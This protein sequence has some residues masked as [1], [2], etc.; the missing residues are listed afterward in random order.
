MVKEPT[1]TAIEEHR[2]RT[3][4]TEDLRRSAAGPA[5]G[6]DAAIQVVL[7]LLVLLSPL[8]MGAVAP[9]ARGAVFCAAMLIFALW[10]AQGFVRGRLC[11]AR[12][13]LWPLILAFFGL[14][15]FQL[16]PLPV[17]VLARLSPATFETRIHSTGSPAASLALSLFPYGTRSEICRLVALA[18]IFFVVAN[19][20]RAPRQVKILIL[21]LAA[22][23]VFEALY[24][25]AEQFSGSRHIFWQ[26]R[27]SH[28]EAVTGT[29]PN[30]NHF[31]GLQAMALTA[32]LGLIVALIPRN[33]RSR[34]AGKARLVAGISSP[35]TGQLMFLFGA[36]LLMAVAIVFSLSRAGILCAL[37]SLILFATC[38]GLAGGF[39]KYT[40]LLFFLVA[41]VVV[42]AA[43]VGTEI[44]LQRFEEAA[45]GRSASWADRL[46]LSRSGLRLL[47]EFPL[48]GTGLGTFRFAFE[49]FQSG[50]FGDHVADFLHNDWLQVSCETGVVG[51]LIVFAAALVFLLGA[52]RA[53]FGR[54]DAF[55]RWT[56]IGALIAVVG[57][58]LHSFFDYNLS[59]ITSN[60]I[61]FAALA[62]VAFAASRMPS[63]HDGSA[64]QRRFVA[65]PLGPA[66]LRAG[67]ALLAGLVA[68]GVCIPSAKAALADIHFNR[69]LA[70]SRLGPVDDYFFIPAGA[71]IS[72]AVAEDSLARA[73]ELDPG[74]PQYH[75]YAALQAEARAQALDRALAADSA[76]RIV[77]PALQQAA[78]ALFDR[79]V[80]ALA[81]D[82]A[83]Q[84][85]PEQDRQLAESA[86]QVRL[87]IERL[88][89][90]A[91]YH[92][93][94]AQV[95][96]LR[97]AAS[98]SGPGGVAEDHY[99]S[100]AQDGRPEAEPANLD[101][102]AVLCVNR[103]LWLAPAK[104]CIAYAAGRILLQQSQRPCN[105]ESEIAAALSCRAVALQQLKRAIRFDA[106]Y[107][108]QVYPLVR[109]VL[110]GASADASA[111]TGRGVPAA[112]D[113]LLQVTPQTLYAYE[114]LAQT[115]WE[116]QDW[117]TLLGCLDGMEKMCA[118]EEAVAAA[119][120]W[121]FRSEG[122]SAHA[123]SPASA[124]EFDEIPDA[125]TLSEGAQ[126]L[127][128][129]RLAIAQRRCAVLGI[130]A[131][132]EERAAA[133]AP[134]RALLRQ[135]LRPQ[136]QE[137]DAL[138]QGQRFHEAAE[139]LLEAL[140]QDGANPEALL[141]AAEL[142]SQRAGLDDLPGWNEP[143]DHL[144]SLV[145]H[146]GES[147][148]G[149]AAASL[150]AAN[151]SRMQAV[152]SKLDLSRKN[153][154]EQFEAEFIR[155]AALLAAGRPREAIPALEALAL[156][157]QQSRP[158]WRQGHLVW[159]RLGRAYEA[160]SDRAR[161]IESYRHAVES[162]PSHRDSLVR[163]TALSPDFS[164]DLRRLTPS[165][166][167]DV[168]F[169]DRIT[170]L[171]Y[172]LSR[173]VQPAEAGRNAEWFI[174]YY[175]QVDD[176]VPPGYNP[177]A[178]FCDSDWQ[179]LFTDDHVL[180]A[181]DEPYPTVSPRCG[182]VVIEKRRLQY[183]PT[184]ARY[185]RVGVYNPK[186]PR[187]L[188]ASM[189][190]D[191]GASL[192]VT[193]LVWD[194]PGLPHE[195]PRRGDPA[196]SSAPARVP[197]RPTLYEDAAR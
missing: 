165:V 179:I 98:R 193:P 102:N 1:R 194:A 95:L 16:I 104:P 143:L 185:L 48:F 45:A 58:L 195:T 158:P 20:L 49:R 113:C 38:L 103:A 127:L 152:L 79:I 156:R 175:W 184:S 106:E 25:F 30:K 63:G 138:L 52:A 14:A 89:I 78:P 6:W 134:C 159:N 32:T 59:K 35:R 19:T 192:F 29:F 85:S 135:T 190:F 17:A 71:P 36:A 187:P 76:R 65:I 151:L 154:S 163:L 160:A 81:G 111:E 164:K 114:R 61:L 115:L 110:G 161:A 28:L 191:A 87:A 188:A 47:R 26:A 91:D 51:G 167:C 93:L 77:G 145:L 172:D 149:N 80:E 142:S 74:N 141:A 105:S 182:E 125:R 73:Q 186:P 83:L 13:W 155:T 88:P 132:W 70:G 197:A 11:V 121:T 33:S 108:D 31:A 40:L 119:S 146:D 126:G 177:S 180:R 50:R 57:M 84:N 5:D 124:A 153:P 107:T 170:F 116:T 174:T 178:Q 166:A 168:A 43:G 42:I 82:M 60:G 147:P 96:T 150:T 122:K 130:L 112:T 41:A 139:A 118:R 8:A 136:I 137:S 100:L 9:W 109:A 129:L 183:D 117:P 140:W 18:L 97:A 75:Y 3:R 72:S 128:K 24:G 27:T 120:P 123:A 90:A 23:G 171:G 181:G 7:V 162:L 15:L 37:F 55:C 169:G 56:A 54:K 101:A 44:A 157:L 12:T 62:G 67:L 64:E 131:R 66:P 189:C 2:E 39:R 99:P 53:A 148:S 133:L 196:G 10:L 94:L 86:R 173:E 34:L 21:A 22:A 176:R 46:D 144:F 4:S 69:F 92:L 68:A